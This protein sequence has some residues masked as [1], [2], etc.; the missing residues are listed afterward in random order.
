MKSSKPFIRISLAVLVV[1][2]AWSVQGSELVPQTW[3][4]EKSPFSHQ[5][6]QPSP[7]LGPDYNAALLG[8]NPLLHPFLKITREETAR[9]ALLPVYPPTSFRTYNIKDGG[10]RLF[11]IQR[12]FYGYFWDNS[13][14]IND[15]TGKHGVADL[16]YTFVLATPHI[17]LGY[18]NT[19]NNK[20]WKVGDDDITRMMY[21]V[22]IDYKVTDSFYV[23]PVFTYYDW[24]KQSEVTSK[25]GINKEWISGL[26]FRFIF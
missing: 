7:I 6:S 25:P 15:T 21:G 10:D 1:F 11:T 3:L 9:Q 2:T 5:L 24:S 23:I 19:K 18:E 4:P 20:D 17:Y 12:S 13:G 14:R 22:S 8:V 26:Q 16:A